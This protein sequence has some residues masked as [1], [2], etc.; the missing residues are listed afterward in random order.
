MKVYYILYGYIKRRVK[1]EN[2]VN[3]ILHGL[4]SSE[5]VSARVVV[6]QGVL[7]LTVVHK[8]VGR[9]SMKLG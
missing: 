6:P 7:I 9:R 3:G 2:Q 1:V 4:M 8:K 5:N